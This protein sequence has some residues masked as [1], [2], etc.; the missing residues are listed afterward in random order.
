[1]ERY[2]RLFPITREWTY[3][4]H[5]SIGPLPDPVTRA[6]QQY[7]HSQSADGTEAYPSWLDAV[8][9][10]R[11]SA[12]RLLGA[13]VDEISFVRNVAEGLSRISLGLRWAP[14]DNI[15]TCAMEYPTNVLPWL[16]LASEGVETRIAPVEGARVTVES[17]APYVDARTRLVAV[18]SVQFAS[19]HQLDLRALGAFCRERG[20]LLSVDAIQHLGAFPL[21]V[22]ATPVDF[23][24]AGGHKW[25]LSPCGTGIFYCRRD[26]L[27][28]LR[29]VEVGY[30]GMSTYD[31]GHELLGCA[32]SPRPTAQR[33]EG[34]LAAISGLAGLGA[35]ID[36]VLEVGLDR[37]SR[38]ILELTDATVEGLETLGFR[39]LSPRRSTAEKSGI[40]SFTHATR[41]AGEIKHFLAGRR[42][43]VSARVAG[44]VP[45]VR[46]SPHFYNTQSEIRE[47]LDALS[48]LSGTGC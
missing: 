30:A 42:I 46:I 48:H 24:T 37:I 16:A 11:A 9:H 23:V 3:L 31:L 1:M 44:G 4:Q 15:V 35:A 5:A 32:F 20:V 19:G 38:H 13:S 33:F 8:E 26:L 10:T 40:V 7:L 41:P 34:G 12:A 45:F 27:E 39:V 17:L 28:T 29:I 25:L 21:D 36:L 6:A 18:S 2:R 14:G 43:S 22:R 47:V